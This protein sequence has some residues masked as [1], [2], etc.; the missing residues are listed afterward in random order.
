LNL[1]QICRT[2]GDYRRGA[3]VFAQ[4]AELLQ[5]DL[6]RERF[7]RALH[8]AVVAREHLVKCLTELGEFQ[9]ALALALAGELGMRPLQAHCHLGPSF[10]YAKIG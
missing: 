4:T 9:Q 6:A 10:L 8:P 5:G 2:M 3:T 7:G 1:G